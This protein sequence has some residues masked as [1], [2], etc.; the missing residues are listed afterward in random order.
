M[1]MKHGVFLILLL[2]FSSCVD[3]KKPEQ[4][5]SMDTLSLKLSESQG[6]KHEL[7]DSVQLYLNKITTLDSL[8]KHTYSNDTLSYLTAQTIDSFIL[9][10]EEFPALN[11]IITTIDSAIILKRNS[12]ECLSRDVKQGRGIQSK[13]AEFIAF[14]QAEVIKIDKQLTKS[15]LRLIQLIES[16]NTLFPKLNDY[17]SSSMRRSGYTNE[18]E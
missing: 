1:N 7:M 13:Y 9:L 17:L 18:N 11:S 12:I 3:L 6:L 10:K 14:E 2:L 5:K 8:L 16:F 15:Q 4:L